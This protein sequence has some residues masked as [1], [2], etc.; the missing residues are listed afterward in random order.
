MPEVRKTGGSSSSGAVIYDITRV[1]SRSVPEVCVAEAADAAAFSENARELARACEAV[2][3]APEVRAARV[4]ALKRQIENGAYSAD[5]REVARK[6]LE[7][8]F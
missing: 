8:G 3:G 1:R 2:N 4:K 5:P 6:L 7:L